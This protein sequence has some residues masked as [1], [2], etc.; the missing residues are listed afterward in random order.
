MSAFVSPLV[1]WS[2]G[3]A[4]AAY[5]LWKVLYFFVIERFTSPLRD[6]P[7]P[8]NPSWLYGNLQEISEAENSVRQEAWVQEYGTTLKYK[9]WFSRDRVYTIDMRAMNHILTH[10]YDFPKPPLAR[11]SLSQ[12]LG[13][14]LLVV[15]GEQHRQQRRILNPAFGPAQ[16]RGLTEVFVEKAY[17]LRTMWNAELEKHGAPA[18]IDVHAGLSRATLDVIGLAG[19]NYELGSLSVDGSTNEL[20]SAFAV[21]FQALSGSQISFIRM[22]KA[23]IPLLRVIPD[24]VSRRTAAAQKVTRRI[25]LQLIAEKKAEIAKAAQHGEKDTLRSRDLLTLLM[26][27]NMSTDIPENQRLSDEDVLAQ[28]P[29]FLVAGH[30]TTSNATAWCLYA[31]AGAP[32]VQARLREELLAW[33]TDNPTMDELNEL[34]Y[35]DM[36]VRETMRLHAP[37]AATIRVAAK[38]EVVPLGKPYTDRHGQVH[39]SVTIPKG[40]PVLIPILAMN[41]S[42]ELWGE[43]SFEFKPERWEA[44]PEPVEHMPGVW[45]HMMS[46]LGGPRACIG[47]RFS[48]VEMKA[49]VFVLVR[50]FEFEYAVPTSE[51]T[52]KQAIVQRPFVKSEMEKGS[53]LPLIVKPY[54]RV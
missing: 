24:R 52:K 1:L 45:S 11:W 5:A 51:I 18:R 28:V 9:G 26:R 25:G 20:N 15:E 14:G 35:L 33:P 37:V 7:S 31:L 13:A 8:P 10:S 22:L 19:F 53:Q 38:D 12:I 29:T 48:L 42:K 2:L 41:R 39:D 47:Y 49:L 3:A 23:Y 4:A 36:V 27:A 44:I 34:P 46:F 6:L 40:S 16:I 17:E 54:V 43:D 30:E 21:M 50:A 32:D